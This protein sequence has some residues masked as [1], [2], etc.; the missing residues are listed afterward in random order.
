MCTRTRSTYQPMCPR[1][2]RHV[3]KGQG[4]IGSEEVAETPP[5]L[6]T[7]MYPGGAGV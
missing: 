2:Q 3:G 1:K 6:S 4:G 5:P 7:R